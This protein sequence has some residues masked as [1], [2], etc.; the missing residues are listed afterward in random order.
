[1]L[2][3]SGQGVKLNAGNWDVNRGGVFV[4]ANEAIAIEQNGADMMVAA[5]TY[6]VYM[7]ADATELYFMEEGKTPVAASDAVT[8]G[9]CK[10][11]KFIWTDMGE[12][13]AIVDLGV[14]TPGKLA[15]CYDAAAVYG[16]ENLPAEM[17]GMYMQYL[18]WDYKVEATDATSGVFTISALDHFGELV[19]TQGTYAEWNGTT[20]VVNFEML[21]ISNVTMTVAEETIP[22][23]IEQ[24]GV[25]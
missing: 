23:Y 12:A 25:M 22:V 20:C 6:D 14:T 2:F 15:V 7:N 1:M 11:R 17:V 21:M 19:E 13:P 16:A 5:G 3:R 9:D 8:T 18:A 10:G 24:G 4:A